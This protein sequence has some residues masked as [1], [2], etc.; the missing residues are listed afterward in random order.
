MSEASQEYLEHGVETRRV[1]YEVEKVKRLNKAK[2]EPEDFNGHDCGNLQNY[3]VMNEFLDR[4]PKDKPLRMLDLGCGF[5]MEPRR[6]VKRHPNISILATDLTPGFIKV[7]S[8]INEMCQ[9]QDQIE[10][11]VMDCQSPELLELGKFDAII[12]VGVLLFVREKERLFR[13]MNQ[14]IDIGSLIFV[15]DNLLAPGYD[16]T[17]EEQAALDEFNFNGYL[18]AGQY[19]TAFENAGFRVLQY[20]D[21]TKYA[22]DA[23][24]LLGDRYVS[25][26]EEL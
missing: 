2:Y 14:L 8:T 15:D 13:R 12:S 10:M 18:T 7:G 16:L 6:I 1:A 22:T 23:E 24:C 25:Q 11:K 9:M 26:K 3:D 21:K 20:K 19:I 4:L 5:G 17:P